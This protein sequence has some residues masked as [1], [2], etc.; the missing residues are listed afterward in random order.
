MASADPPNDDHP[1]LQDPDFFRALNA[2]RARAERAK[3][4]KTR[5][6]QDWGQEQTD[7]E[8]LDEFGLN[9]DVLREDP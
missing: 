7:A 3:A 4:E 2:L 8:I 6:L 1:E 5:A 9:M